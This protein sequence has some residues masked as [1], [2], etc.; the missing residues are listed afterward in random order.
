[1]SVRKGMGGHNEQGAHKGRSY[2]GWGFV[3]IDGLSRTMM[4]VRARK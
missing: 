4:S 3:A 1:M 2:Y